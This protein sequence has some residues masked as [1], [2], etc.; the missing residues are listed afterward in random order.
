MQEDNAISDEMKRTY[1]FGRPSVYI[2]K[3]K[4]EQVA[5]SASSIGTEVGF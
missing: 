3:D 1:A 2:D 5:P 4:N